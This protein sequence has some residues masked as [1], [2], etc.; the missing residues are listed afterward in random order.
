MKAVHNT[1]ATC[2]YFEPQD[3]VFGATKGFCVRRAPFAALTHSPEGEISG[4]HTFWPVVETGQS[5]GEHSY[6]GATETLNA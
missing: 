4:I 1:C 3:D 2:A 6:T 5:C